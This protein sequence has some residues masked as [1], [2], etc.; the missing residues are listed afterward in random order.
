MPNYSD[1]YDEGEFD[2]SGKYTRNAV[3]HQTHWPERLPMSTAGARLPKA[4]LRMRL[5]TTDPKAHHPLL[6]CTDGRTS[7]DAFRSKNDRLYQATTDGGRLACGDE[8]VSRA[9]CPYLVLASE[10]DRWYETKAERTKAGDV[11]G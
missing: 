11:F 7:G 10:D 6:P 5:R 8:V 9:G 2:K 3:T 1:E 4:R